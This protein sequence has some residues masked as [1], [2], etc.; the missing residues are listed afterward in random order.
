MNKLKGKE[1]ERVFGYLEERFGIG[2]GLFGGYDFRVSPKGKAFISNRFPGT[3]PRS[4]LNL[5]LPFV[6]V[7]RSGVIKPTSVFIQLFGRH[8]KKGIV[9]IGKEQAKRFASGMDLEIGTDLSRGYVIV[10]YGNYD[11]GCGRLK[12]GILKNMLPKGKRMNVE[13]L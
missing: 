10:R 6:R 13:L 8:A 2:R 9:N 11:L 1:L 7:G 12:E 5:G 3:D 4:A